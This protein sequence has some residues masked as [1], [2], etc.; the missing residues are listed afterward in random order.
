MCCAY[1]TIE[2]IL[3]LS[4]VLFKQERYL[5]YTLCK[6]E[7]SDMSLRGRYARYDSEY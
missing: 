2:D 7:I 6:Y 5:Q 1:R 3:A 4:N